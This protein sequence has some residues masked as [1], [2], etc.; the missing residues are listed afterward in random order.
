MVSAMLQESDN[1]TPDYLLDKLGADAMDD[2]IQRYIPGYVDTPQSI[3]A[4]FTSWMGSPGSP[5]AG[6]ANL[7]AYSGIFSF[8]Y[9][10]KEL[11]GLFASLHSPQ[12]LQAQRQFI[13]ATPPWQ[14]PP[15]TCTFGSGITEAVQRP[16]ETGYFP[17]SNTRSYTNLMTGLLERNLL[18]SHVQ[19]IVE[20]KL[21][22]R[23]ST[24]GQTF[25]R[26]GAKGGSLGTGLGYTILTWTAYV[27]TQQN[28]PGSKNG[29]QAVVTIHLQDRVNGSNALQ[30]LVPGVTHFADALVEDPAFAAMVRL[31]LPD[32]PA[33]PDLIARIT[34]LGPDFPRAEPTV[35]QVRN[36][37]SAHTGRSTALDVFVSDT[38]QL[39]PG[40]LPIYTAQVPPLAPEGS[41]TVK[42]DRLPRGKFI[43]VVVDPQNLIVESDK[44]NNAQYE[45][46]MA[47]R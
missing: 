36:I 27:E 38:S 22:W 45:K 19:A 8:G 20:P 23:L 18:P 31:Q 44:Q 10:H 28:A 37:G 40:A 1:A 5:L 26:Y 15:P 35:I 33:L 42:I 24:L 29:T 47:L 17:Q 34:Q 13:C 7:A 14:A 11:P 39:P 12:F 46:L 21:E 43:I 2:V 4:L 41:M 32:D 30:A 6:A 25:R 9:S 16:L 3:G